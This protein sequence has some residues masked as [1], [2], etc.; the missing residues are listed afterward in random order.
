[1]NS[2]G[3]IDHQVIHTSERY[4]EMVTN[5]A[6]P[7]L[8]SAASWAIAMPGLTVGNVII[9][10]ENKLTLC[11][12]TDSEHM[13][14]LFILSGRIHSTFDFGNKEEKTA[15]RKQKHAFQYSA[16]YEAEHEILTDHLHALSIDTSPSFFKSLM[17][18]TD[19]MDE[20]INCFT[21]QES[22]RSILMLQPRMAEIINLIVDCPFKGVTRYL[23]IESKVLELLALQMEQ[24]KTPRS[25]SQAISNSDI[26]KLWAVKAFVENNYLERLSLAGLCKTFSLNEFKLKKGYKELF[27]TTVFGHINSL[28]MD[29]ARQLLSQKQLTVSEVADFIGYKNVASFS[30]EFKKRFG[31]M[32]SRCY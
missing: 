25:A 27:H 17:G 20:L 7:H 24:I 12:F 15:I 10:P 4:F 26:E 19:E 6:E 28:R 8:A 13:R 3:S 5:F 23:F 14:S 22:F 32:P 11:D 16:E 1:M 29:K 9:K 31:C 21:K 18:T 30:V 2:F